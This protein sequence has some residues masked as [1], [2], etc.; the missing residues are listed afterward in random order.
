MADFWLLIVFALVALINLGTSP[1]TQLPHIKAKLVYRGE[2]S[3][4]IRTLDENSPRTRLGIQGDNPRW[5]PDGTKI[6]FDYSPDGV[7]SDI[8]VVN[9]DGTG[10]RQL[11]HTLDTDAHPVWSPDGNRIVFFSNRD[12]NY[13]IY[14]MKFDGTNQIRLTNN[15]FTDQ[16]PVWSPNGSEIAFDSYRNGNTDIYVI[17]SDGTNERRLTDY[18]GSDNYVEWSPN[19]QLAF[20][21]DLSSYDF[22]YHTLSSDNLRVNQITSDLVEFTNFRW[23][24]DGNAL[25]T[26]HLDLMYLNVSTGVSTRISEWWPYELAGNY[27]IWVESIEPTNEQP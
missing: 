14:V 3:L 2:N 18:D 4:Y 6:V 1:A 23:L 9:A 24:P 27:D 25:Y 17:N 10:L 15:T 20:V 13:E 22:Q 7:W 12:G 8:Y 5:S 11:T 21:R 19:T 16:S 26:H